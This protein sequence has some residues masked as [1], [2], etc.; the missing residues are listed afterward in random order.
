MM[1]IVSM[2][3]NN[4][5]VLLIDPQPFAWDWMHGSQEPV[6][7]R[8]EHLLM[9]AD[10][11]Q[12]PTIATFEHPVDRKGLMPEKLEIVFPSHGQRFIKHTYNCCSEPEIL[13]AIKQ[14]PIQQIAVAGAETDVCVLQSVLGLLRL[15]YQVFLLED[16]LFTSEAHPRPALDRMYQAGAIPSSYKTFAYELTLSVDNSPWSIG[17]KNKDQVRV[18]PDHF[19]RPEK[20]PQ[21]E[22][23][24]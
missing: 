9:L 20:L 21:W 12:L 7:M 24:R 1:E 10:W 2:D 22:P 13:A 11:M 14:L 4:V 23:M 18:L 16:C 3:R 6:L 15:D 19:L 17:W 5:G 8:L